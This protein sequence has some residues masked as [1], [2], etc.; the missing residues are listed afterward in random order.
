MLNISQEICLSR[1]S[2][3]G[4]FCVGLTEQ[5]RH[6]T[7]H[8]STLPGKLADESSHR[9]NYLSSKT[10]FIFSIITENAAWT[11]NDLSDGKVR[12]KLTCSPVDKHH[13]YYIFSKEIK[14]KPISR[15]CQNIR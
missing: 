8:K 6:N 7:L 15:D 13:K 2:I 14:I 10:L 1:V 4:A 11:K 12:R 9:W 5:R 3:V